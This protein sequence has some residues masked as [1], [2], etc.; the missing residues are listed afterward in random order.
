MIDPDQL[1]A[2]L[3]VFAD[4]ATPFSGSLVGNDSLHVS[5]IRD[6]ERSYIC[7]L[8]NG[9]I[10]SRRSEGDKRFPSVAS[11]L[12]SEE[13]IDIRKFRASQRR[14]L[15]LQQE[16]RGGDRPVLDPEGVFI[17]D[18]PT[19]PLTRAT[20]DA[21][22]QHGQSGHLS[23]LLID[24]P[25]GIGKT[26]LI[27]RVSLTRSAPDADQPPLLHVVSGGSKLTDLSKALA[28]SLQVIRSLATFDQVPILA[29][30]GV[31]QVAIDGFDELVDPD[32][33]RDAWSALREFLGDVKEGGPIVLSGR[34]TFFDQQSFE[35]LLAKRI[36]HLK[37]TQV[38]LE[39]VSPSAAKQY[40]AASGWSEESLANAQSAG[41]FRPGSYQLRPFFLAQIA[42]EA[43]W[44]ELQ[45]AH[46]SPQAFLVSRMV[47]REAR[48]ISKA[49]NISA[50]QAEKGLWDFFGAI[51]EDMSIQQSDTVDEAFVAFACETSF[52]NIVAPQDLAKLVHRASSFALLESGSAAGTRRFPHSEFQNQFAARMLVRLI[53]SASSSTPFIRQAVIDSGLAEAFADH[54][55]TLGVDLVIHIRCNLLKMLAA[56]SFSARAAS[57][58]G[59]LLIA[60]LSRTDLDALDISSVEITEGRIL[61]TSGKARLNQVNFGQLDVRGSDCRDILFNNCAIGSLV[62]DA[63]TILPR[64]NSVSVLQFEKEG[65]VDVLRAPNDIKAALKRLTVEDS[66]ET[67]NLPFVR[68]FDR[69][70]R[71]F[72]RQYQIRN[73]SEDESYHF[74]DNDFWPIAREILGPLVSVHVK[75]AGGPRSEFFRLENPEQLLVP[76]P[77]ST[78]D[79][80]RRA[81]VRKAQ[82]LAG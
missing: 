75:Q 51:A 50:D 77:G 2:D 73:H 69:L 6:V 1:L 53:S 67:A 16:Q 26:S 66:S 70:C 37:V 72:M 14:I 25:A 27:E 78:F 55:L 81:V 45:F 35:K 29:R 7:N 58:I 65:R 68:Y 52:E 13:F 20:F 17:G 15:L 11:L 79:E 60:T 49:V 54:C 24:G 36:Q 5:M 21:A 62:A 48:L 56:E 80:I 18:G 63:N 31:I 42:E 41:W 74:L 9:S 59:S 43:G 22:L 76:L 38:R 23:V 39:P 33:Y 46:G 82:E 8:Q 3:R 32:G 30:L 64:I 34:D 10:I 4:P 19:D 57:N 12:A 61:G 40:L 71:A 28:H 47:G 44:D